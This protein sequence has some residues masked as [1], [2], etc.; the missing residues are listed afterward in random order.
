MIATAQGDSLL[1]Y[2]SDQRRFAVLYAA[3]STAVGG[4][5][6]CDLHDEFGWAAGAAAAA[7]A[8]SK[9]RGGVYT[10]ARSKEGPLPQRGRRERGDERGRRGH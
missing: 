5:L 3:I 9:E 2:R 10:Q 4:C 1:L 6:E 8:R 7:E